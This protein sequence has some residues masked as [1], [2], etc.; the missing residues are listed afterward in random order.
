MVFVPC[1][2]CGWPPT[3]SLTLC[4]HVVVQVFVGGSHAQVLPQ[5]SSVRSRKPSHSDVAAAFANSGIELG[6]VVC[7]VCGWLCR[8]RAIMARD[9]FSWAQEAASRV[10][11]SLHLEHS[12]KAAY[13][14]PPVAQGRAGTTSSPSPDTKYVPLEAVDLE[15]ALPHPDVR[16]SRHE[17][18]LATE[19][20]MPKPADGATPTP[21]VFVDGASAQGGSAVYAQLYQRAQREEQRRRQTGCCSR[22]YARWVSGAGFD[23]V[24]LEV[25][26]RAMPDLLRMVPRA[27]N[28]PQS[29]WKCSH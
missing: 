26:R 17:A 8:E 2:P 13:K 18:R 25:F 1:Y 7:L 12:P 16:A 27:K 29:T 15:D 19:A 6:L 11:S 28:A 5:E 20:G 4:V 21:L 23:D 14:A 9:E 10:T 3:L 24:R 22:M